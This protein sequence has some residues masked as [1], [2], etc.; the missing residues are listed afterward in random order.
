MR[1]Q[2][3]KH[4]SE[5][6]RVRKLN[7]FFCRYTFFLKRLVEF[8]RKHDKRVELARQRQKERNEAIQ[9][10]VEEQRRQ[11]IRRNLECVILHFF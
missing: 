6:I 4:R 10:K 1:E 8:V 9:H 3:K 2:G 7:L 11:T 5:D